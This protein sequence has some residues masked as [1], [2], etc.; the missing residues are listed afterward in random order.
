MLLMKRQ[1]FEMIRA[2]QK[3]TTLR[4]WKTCRV[5]PLSTHTV[6][7]LGKIHIQDAQAVDHQKLTEQ[8]ALADGFENLAALHKALETM[9]DAQARS[10]RQLFKITFE[11]IGH[12][13]IPRSG[14][15]E[16]REPS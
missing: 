7:G 8:D 4:Y 9:Y 12:R 5:K 11:L 13:Q 15:K 2:G 16:R 1:F 14:P 10:E 6:P 3:T